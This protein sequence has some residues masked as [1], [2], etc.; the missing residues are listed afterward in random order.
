MCKYLTV[1]L[2]AKK[3]PYIT[4][5]QKIAQRMQYIENNFLKYFWSNKMLLDNF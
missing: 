3:L 4:D 2:D 5:L 1:L